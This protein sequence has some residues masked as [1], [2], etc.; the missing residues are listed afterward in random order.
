MTIRRLSRLTLG[1]LIAVAGFATVPSSAMAI[2]CMSGTITGPGPYGGA[3]VV[4]SIYDVNHAYDGTISGNNNGN[5]SACRPPGIY[6]VEFPGPGGPGDNYISQYWDDSPS[7]L[8]STEVDLV[9]G[10]TTE[11]INATMV[12]GGWVKG[13]IT[14]SGSG[15]A[16]PN[17]DISVIEGSA[18][19]EQ[20][21]SLADGSY[22][23]G[24]LTPGTYTLEFSGNPSYATLDIPN[25]HVASDA[26]TT[27]NAVLQLAGSGGGSGGT[28]QGGGP[29][30]PAP[31]Q[32]LPAPVPSEKKPLKCHK[33][34]RKQVKKGKASC[35]RIGHPHRHH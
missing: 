23:T 24:L 1:A 10:M 5:W 3:G 11:H 9:E 21:M 13:T 25:V 4:P 29:A 28:E 31:V 26:T 20:R 16:V 6:Y 32:P 34:F 8:G 19:I 35:V 30:Q 18:T 17:L 14:A 22:V 15:Q 33:G 27:S 7:L 12:Q 2:A